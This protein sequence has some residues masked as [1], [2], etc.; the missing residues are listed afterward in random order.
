MMEGGIGGNRSGYETPKPNEMSNVFKSVYTTS[1]ISPLTTSTPAK[2]FP[3]PSF[4]PPTRSP[5]STVKP[6]PSLHDIVQT[7][8]DLLKMHERTYSRLG[9]ILHRVARNQ[10]S[11]LNSKNDLHICYKI[12]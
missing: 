2:S 11:L 7:Q 12:I 8:T 3:P 10:E 5:A 6:A 1:P 4:I 9:D